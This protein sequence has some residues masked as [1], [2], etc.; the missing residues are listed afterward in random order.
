MDE[1]RRCAMRR[2]RLGPL[3]AAIGL[4]CLVSGSG[5]CATGLT[6]AFVVGTRMDW[7]IPRSSTSRFSLLMNE[8]SQALRCNARSIG[9]SGACSLVAASPAADSRRSAGSMPT[10]CRTGDARAA[11]DSVAAP[12]G[13]CIGLCKSSQAAVNV[14]VE[15]EVEVDTTG[16]NADLFSSRGR[17]WGFSCVPLSGRCSVVSGAS[18]GSASL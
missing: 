4:R 1:A 16:R 12:E 17:A 11:V 3:L 2:Y 18:P 10:P 9:D 7:R 5:A 6:F 13:R 14:T 8:V 15:V